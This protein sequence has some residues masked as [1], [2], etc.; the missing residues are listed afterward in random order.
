MRR[1]LGFMGVLVLELSLSV[2]VRLCV[3]VSLLSLRVSGNGLK[4]K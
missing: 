3:Y 2:F 4:L 1:D